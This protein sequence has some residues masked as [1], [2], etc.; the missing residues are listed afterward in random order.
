MIQP[1]MTSMETPSRLLRLASASA[2]E[3]YSKPPGGSGVGTVVEVFSGAAANVMGVC[4]ESGTGVF[5]GP[6]RA[7]RE[8]LH[9]QRLKPS[10]IPINK[11]LS[12]KTLFLCFS[13]FPVR[14]VQTDG[15]PS[16]RL[17]SC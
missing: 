10:R 6:G 2:T 1:C 14:P 15:V 16:A 9:A 12:M 8:L 3:A 11:V 13:L 7:A 4:M 17:T 5:V